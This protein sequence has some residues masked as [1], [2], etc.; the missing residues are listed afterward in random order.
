MARAFE[1]VAGEDARL[2]SSVAAAATRVARGQALE[3]SDL[4]RDDVSVDEY[5]SRTSDKTA[6][7]FELSAKLGAIGGGFGEVEQDL[8]AEYGATIGL[9]FQLADDLRDLMGGAALGRERGTDVREGVYT[10]PLILTLAS[11]CPGA[12]EL[13]P[14][15][16]RVRMQREQQMI[17]R[18]CDIVLTSGAV[19]AT[20]VIM[21]RYV[22]RAVMLAHRMPASLARSLSM[23]AI[24]LTPG[25]VAAGH[26]RVA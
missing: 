2:R 21:R 23:L 6:A 12:E 16:R 10:L 15:L 17:D 11:G 18:C 13:R 22:E 1:C 7:L 19:D 9:V 14:L 5:V 20:V 26:G 8:A 25:V 3:M 24:K 4:Y